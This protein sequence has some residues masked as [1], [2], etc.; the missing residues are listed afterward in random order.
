MVI[1]EQRVTCECGHVFEAQLV[2]NA[3]I[4]EVPP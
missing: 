4:A 1:S 3:P 2:M